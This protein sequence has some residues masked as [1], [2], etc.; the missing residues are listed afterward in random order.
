M[1]KEEVEDVVAYHLTRRS[2]VAATGSEA[3]NLWNCFSHKKRE[4]AAGS[5][6]LERLVR[7]RHVSTYAPTAR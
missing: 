7:W 3:D 2:S 5:R 1:R 4:R 6:R